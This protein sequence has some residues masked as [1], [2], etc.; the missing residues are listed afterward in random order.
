ML[1]ILWIYFTIFELKSPEFSLIFGMN[2]QTVTK[3]AL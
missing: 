2:P 1:L 3:T